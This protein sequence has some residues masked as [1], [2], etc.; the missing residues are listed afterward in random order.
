MRRSRR[1]FWDTART[2]G[3]EADKL[4]AFATLHECLVTVATLLAPFMPFVADELYRNLVAGE[5]A[6]RVRPPVRLAGRR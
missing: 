4:A 5:P 2:G 6:P 1:R 3:G